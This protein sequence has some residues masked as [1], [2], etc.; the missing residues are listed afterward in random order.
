LSPRRSTSPRLDTPLLWALRG[1]L[2]LTG[3][4]PKC[5]NE[6]AGLM[7]TTL[8]ASTVRLVAVT[9]VARETGANHILPVT[10][11]GRAA[12]IVLSLTFALFGGFKLLEHRF[13]HHRR[14]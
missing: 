14:L 12:L 5:G 8:I 3:A 1:E 9:R 6:V 2:Q 4:L 11:F 10:A 7:R 13:L